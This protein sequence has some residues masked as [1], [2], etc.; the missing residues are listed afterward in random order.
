M[1]WAKKVL[2]LLVLANWFACIVHCQSEEAFAIDRS[3]GPSRA[4]CHAAS[5]P[6]SGGD[7]P[8]ICDWVV[9]GGYKASENR[10]NLP[11]RFSSQFSALFQGVENPAPLGPNQQVL[12][13]WSNAPPKHLN[14]FLDFCRMAL[15]PRAPS[16]LA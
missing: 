4:V 7:C 5:Q 6:Q 2:T 3:G 15:P 13:Q 9:S 1:N 11:D 14:T 12:A 10:V 8:G 16:L